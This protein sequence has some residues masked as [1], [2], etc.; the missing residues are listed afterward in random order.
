MISIASQTNHDFT[1]PIVPFL[2][3]EKL[4]CMKLKQFTSY[5]DGG[6]SAICNG[7]LFFLGKYELIKQRNILIEES[8]KTKVEKSTLKHQEILY[9]A[10]FIEVLGIITISNRKCNSNL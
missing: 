6:N 9:F 10:D 7:I 4:R 5:S 8:L 3:S 1:K 2:K